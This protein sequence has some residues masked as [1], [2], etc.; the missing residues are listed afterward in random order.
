MPTLVTK[1]KTMISQILALSVLGFSFGQPQINAT[2]NYPQNFNQ[3]SPILTSQVVM[4]KRGFSLDYR[5]PVPSV[6][7]VFKDNILLNLAYLNQSIKSSSDIDWDK[8]K[9]EE[10][11]S[12]SLN[13]GEIFA[14]HDQ[15]LPEYEG[16]INLTTNAHF[17]K[18]DGFI[19]DGYLYGDGVCH[20]ASFISWV[21]RDAGLEVNAPTRHDFAAIPE[22]PKSQGVSIYYDPNSYSRSAYQNLYITN[23]QTY[24][25]DIIFDYHD[26]ELTISVV[27]N[28]IS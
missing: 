4:A 13:P 16:K 23:N 22:V 28:L 20:L 19:S 7:E 24:P 11:F 26:G 21:A 3:L 6:S 15:V 1:K 27:K 18:E 17:N 8:V 10:T 2:S 25:I 9:S 14:F 5:Y 12:I